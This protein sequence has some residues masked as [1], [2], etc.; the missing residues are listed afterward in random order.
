MI[1]LMK[2]PLKKVWARVRLRL[3]FSLLRWA[4]FLKVSRLGQFKKL[5]S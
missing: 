1:R 3:Q 4:I 5:R 2:L